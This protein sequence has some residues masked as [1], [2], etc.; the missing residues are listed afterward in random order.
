MKCAITGIE[1]NNKWMNQPISRQVVLAAKKLK[2]V[3]PYLSMSQAFQEISD[4]L[5]KMAIENS[6]KVTQD[7]E[8]G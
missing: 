7:S 8:N 3:R 5:K 2:E 6:V 1:T 4:D